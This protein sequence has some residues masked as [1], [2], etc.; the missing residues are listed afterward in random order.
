MGVDST[1]LVVGLVRRG[2]R[3]HV[4]LFADT[5]GE[6]RETYEY[7]GVIQEFLRREG[8]PPVETVRKVVKDYKNWPP[9]HTLEE[10]CLTNGTLPGI[11]F[12]PATCSVKWKQD[13]QHDHLKR[14]PLVREAWAQGL[15]VT[16]LIGYDASPLDRR[17]TYRAGPPEDGR[18][19]IQYPLIEWGWD[20][21]ECQRQIRAAGL[22][23]PAKSSCFFC[24]AMKPW[25]VEALTPEMLR[26]IVRMEAR[27][28]PRLRTTE[29]LWRSTV[30]GTRGGTARPG[31]M[32]EFIRQR[33]LLPEAEIQHLWD[34][35]TTLILTYQE[36]YAA[37]KAAGTL[38]EFLTTHPAPTC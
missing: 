25:E 27:A 3:P 12:G 34:T 10:N 18:Y 7:E 36:G 37:A 31:S 13:P 15:P 21:E 1:A 4:I 33:R 30:K 17:R 14:L 6:K 8:F 29:G 2:F 20:R 19:A 38:P 26:R 24:C 28:H 23:V 11:S 16:K 5:G 35:T 22:P 9:Y 32:T